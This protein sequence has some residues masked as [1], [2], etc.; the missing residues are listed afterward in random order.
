[1]SE[2]Y[3]FSPVDAQNAPPNSGSAPILPPLEVQDLLD[4]I[5]KID[6]ARENVDMMSDEEIAALL[7]EVAQFEVGSAMQ[8]PASP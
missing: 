8:K 6:Q 5:A 3:P 2:H 7:K 1:M 4:L